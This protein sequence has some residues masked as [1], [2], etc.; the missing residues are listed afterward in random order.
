MSAIDL[1]EGQHREVEDLFEEFEEAPKGRKREVFLQIADK[2]AVHAAIEEKHFYP[3]ARTDETQDLL[4]ESAEEHLAVK[5]VIADLL[6]LKEGDE[7][8]EAKVTLLKEQVEHHVEE[9]EEELFPKVEDL[10]DEITLDAL[11]QEM[12]ATQEELLAKGRPRDQVPAETKEA[13]PI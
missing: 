12:V 2:L 1:L 7:T 4:L 6:K 3:A 10:M 9:E 5:R 11:E 8:F 13:A